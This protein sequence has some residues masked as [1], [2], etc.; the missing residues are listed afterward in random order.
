MS[1]LNDYK[2]RFLV[3]DAYGPFKSIISSNDALSG[4]ISVFRSDN[5][6]NALISA[7]VKA[8]NT[9]NIPQ[10]FITNRAMMMCTISHDVTKFYNDSDEFMDNESIP[11][12]FEIPTAH[13]K[14]IVEAW[15]DF[16]KQ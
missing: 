11:P 15:I 12:D 4:Y 7:I 10:I 3:I 8:L 13:L 14:I 5:D 16:L 9:N 6:T 2:I 1:V